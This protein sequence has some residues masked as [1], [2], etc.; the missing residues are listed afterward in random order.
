LGTVFYFA[1]LDTLLALQAIIHSNTQLN[2]HEP[3]FAQALSQT[4][5]DTLRAIATISLA[6][7]NSK[8]TSIDNIVQPNGQKG[9]E[10]GMAYQTLASNYPMQTLMRIF[11]VNG[12]FY[13]F[14]LT[15]V[16]DDVVRLYNYS[17][18]FFKSI[19]IN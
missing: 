15:A 3:V 9:L 13:A 10:F 16:N 1:P 11:M 7:S 4:N 5:G 2:I 19:E 12:K 14:A 18:P 6:A 8:L 17:V